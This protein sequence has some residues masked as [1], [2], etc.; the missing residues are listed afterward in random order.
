MTARPHDEGA[1]R[2]GPLGVRYAPAYEH[3]LYDGSLSMGARLVFF[4][5]CDF[6]NMKDGYAYP[7]RKRLSKELGK[8]VQRVDVWISELE[9]RKLIVVEKAVGRLNHYYIATPTGTDTSTGS[10]TTPGTGTTPVPEVVLPSTG[11]GT[12]VVPE[13]VLNKPYRTT[14]QTTPGP[15]LGAAALD[16]IVETV[17]TENP[18]TADQEQQERVA[19]SEPDQELSNPSPLATNLSESQSEFSSAGEGSSLVDPEASPGAAGRGIS[20]PAEAREV[21]DRLKGGRV[22]TGSDN[23]NQDSPLHREEAATP[24]AASVALPAMVGRG[25]LPQDTDREE[26]A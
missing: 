18:L 20:M 7:G 14:L 4:A 10:G 11:S 2:S 25:S 21:W 16:E 13:V 9:D 19:T 5:L 17:E 24:L 6:W 22:V 26:N 3:V 8:S 15:T 23:D 1:K 12:G